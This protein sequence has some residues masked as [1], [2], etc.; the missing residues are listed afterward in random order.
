MVSKQLALDLTFSSSYLI[1][2]LFLHLIQNHCKVYRFGSLLR[3]GLE[4]LLSTSVH[5]LHYRG[6]N[7]LWFVLLF[8]SRP[9][10][11]P[12]QKVFDTVP[13]KMVRLFA[14]FVCIICLV[15]VEGRRFKPFSIRIEGCPPCDRSACAKVRRSS[16]PSGEL[17]KDACG[18]CRV[19]ASGLGERC[20]GYSW[21]EGICAKGLLCARHLLNFQARVEFGEVGTCVCFERETVCGADGQL[22]DDVCTLRKMNFERKRRGEPKVGETKMRT[23]GGAP[24]IKTRPENV[25]V[26]ESGQFYLTCE[27]EGIPIPDIYWTRGRKK[28]PSDEENVS[29]QVRGGPMKNCVSSW[30]MISQAALKDG[31]EYICHVEN[32][33]GEVNATATV[34]ISV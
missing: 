8:H 16:C 18:C 3:D 31:G 1:S 9:T 10:L 5:S 19:C 29:V 27:G 2:L 11:K 24:K 32:N 4:K 33:E 20:G 22:Y 12:R 15:L 13:K 17:T 28:L 34:D 21:E 7:E 26:T 30:V 14:L 25:A 6:P 23:C